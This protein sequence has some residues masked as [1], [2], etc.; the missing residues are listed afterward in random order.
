[1]THVAN[2]DDI[3]QHYYLPAVMQGMSYYLMDMRIQAFKAFDF[4][5]LC[6]KG[7]TL[8]A[9]VMVVDE[10]FDLLR[11]PNTRDSR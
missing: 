5:A 10:F 8:K 6:L 4:S 7:E 2:D 1:M 3:D 9:T 11:K